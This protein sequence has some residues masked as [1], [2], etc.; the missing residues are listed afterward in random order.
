MVKNGTRNIEIENLLIT[1]GEEGSTS[2]KYAGLTVVNNFPELRR[3][4]C[5]IL[6]E[7][8]SDR[9]RTALITMLLSESDATVKAEAA[10]ALGIIGNDEKGDATG[11]I[12]W[13]IER[14]DSL[15]PDNNFA[16]AAILALERIAIKNNGL[17]NAAG[18]TA[19][20]TIAQG[21]YLRT[22]KDKALEVIKGMGKFNK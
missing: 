10:Y 20:V 18:Y 19:L 15:T 22:V 5:K 2:K 17:K 16:Y 4:A 1:V 13:M 7:I 21:N 14:D 3:Q 11:A 9:A 6:G 8:G 12:G